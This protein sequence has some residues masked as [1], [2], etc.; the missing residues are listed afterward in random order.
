MTKLSTT[1]ANGQIRKNVHT[2]GRLERRQ[3]RK[4]KMR[5]KKRRG[6]VVS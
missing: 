2:L 3:E 6:D 4:K 5:E 1:V